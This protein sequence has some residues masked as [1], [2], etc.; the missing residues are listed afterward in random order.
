MGVIRTTVL[1]YAS[2]TS[3]GVYPFLTL[4]PAEVAP[5]MYEVTLEHLNGKIVK[6]EREKVYFE[7]ALTRV[8]SFRRSSKEDHKAPSPA[9]SRVKEARF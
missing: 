2:Y 7:C 4:S 1:A 3:I 9:P 6:E 8:T 5:K